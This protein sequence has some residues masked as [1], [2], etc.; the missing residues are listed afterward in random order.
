MDADIGFM[1]CTKGTP[2]PNSLHLPHLGFVP[3]RSYM[4]CRQR[5]PERAQR[6]NSSAVYLRGWTRHLVQHRQSFTC[7]DFLVPKS[8]AHGVYKYSLLQHDARLPVRSGFYYPC[9]D[10]PSLHLAT[11]IRETN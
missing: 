1:F 7:D 4:L 3:L 10:A 9:E 8:M 11:L 2:L 6:E 5:T